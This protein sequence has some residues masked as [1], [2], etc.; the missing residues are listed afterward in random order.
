MD[1]PG[2]IHEWP[3]A[4]VLPLEGGRNFRDLGGYASEEGRHVR[5]GVLFRSGSLTGLTRADWNYLALRGVRALCDLRSTS[6]RDSEPVFLT[7][8]PAVSYWA[9]DYTT[10]FAELRAMLRTNFATGEAARRAMIA[11]Y[12]ELPFEQAHA[13]RQL[14][15]HLKAADTPLIFNCSAGKDRAGTAAALIL[16][17]LGVPRMTVVEDFML[18][19]EVLDLQSIL[20]ERSGTSLAKHPPEVVAAI[21]RADPDYIQ[22][23]LDS[24]DDRHGSI[25]GFLR[26]KL[27]V[28]ERE[29]QVIQDALL[30]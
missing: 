13:F 30:E 25:A 5:W 2:S 15:A 27:D 3:Q 1:A 16:R 4:R 22:S 29:L 23:A 11:G 7:D 28:S 12:R 19:N 20:L 24:I 18:T 8:L 14:F 26:D 6:E 17:A 10:S 21:L 9:R